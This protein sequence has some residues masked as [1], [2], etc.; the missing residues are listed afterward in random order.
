MQDDITNGRSWSS[1]MLKMDTDTDNDGKNDYWMFHTSEAASASER[2]YIEY[3]LTTTPYFDL[4]QSGSPISTL[5]IPVGSQF[6][7][8]V[9]VRNIPQTHQM[10][11]L[12]FAV[13]W[14]KTQV[15]YV[16]HTTYAHYWV[17]TVEPADPK[18]DGVIWL[19]R[20]PDPQDPVS[21]Q[22]SGLWMTITFHCLA[23]GTSQITLSSAGTIFLSLSPVTQQNFDPIDIL[24]P[25]YVVTCNQLS[26][27]PSKPYHYV[28]GEL[29]TT[30]KLAVLSPYLALIGVVAVAAV[31]IKRK[32]T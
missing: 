23:Q 5:N 27:A 3:E 28:G 10:V 25:N 18:T 30:N 24:P 1:F 31:L 12:D 4:E 19:Y 17:L 15:E 13:S 21:S 22:D 16:D 6:T 2:P 8:E 20:P 14:D 9:W 7:V 26:R 11:G 29:F 32:L